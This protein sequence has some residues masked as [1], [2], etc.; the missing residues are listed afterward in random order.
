MTVLR[1]GDELTIH[2]LDLAVNMRI[3]FI[4]VEG[5]GTYVRQTDA[6]GREFKEIPPLQARGGIYF[7]DRILGGALDLQAGAGHK[8]ARV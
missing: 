8:R 6:S 1:Q 7:R 4:M 3:G 2:S 5:T